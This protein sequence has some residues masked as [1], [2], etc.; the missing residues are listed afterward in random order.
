MENKNGLEMLLGVI[1]NEKPKIE[2]YEASLVDAS[3]IVGRD[4]EKNKLFKKLLGGMDE[5]T[6]YNLINVKLK[7]K[8]LN[9]NNIY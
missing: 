6:I 5:F 9:V 7:I 1:T 8:K 2:R 4:S 3:G